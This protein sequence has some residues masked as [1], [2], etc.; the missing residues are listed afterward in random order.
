MASWRLCKIV[1]AD[2]I[3]WSG[4]SSYLLY[5]DARDH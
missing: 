5:E 3:I 1:I 2:S 4:P